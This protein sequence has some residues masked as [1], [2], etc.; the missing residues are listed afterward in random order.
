MKKFQLDDIISQLDIP[1]NKWL[2]LNDFSAIILESGRGIYPNWE[3]IRFLITDKSEILIRYGESKAYGAR[4]P[5][6]FDYRPGSDFIEFSGRLKIEDC[7]YYKDFRC[8]KQGDMIRITKMNGETLGEAMVT[9]TTDFMTTTLIKLSNPMM[10][11][12]GAGMSFYD[13]IVYATQESPMHSSIVPG[14][15]MGFT[16]N[17]S[18]VR[19]KRFGC[20]HELIR[21]KDIKEIH[22][23]LKSDRVYK[24]EGEKNEK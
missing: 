3:H 15:Y 23:M 19:N 8:P 22:F 13:P 11:E 1:R 20:C 14:I 5:F 2:I 4:L 16:P 17:F 9:S 10:F 18:K 21:P 6:T 12:R 24:V 7:K